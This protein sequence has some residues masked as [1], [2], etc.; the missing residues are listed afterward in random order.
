MNQTSPIERKTPRATTPRSRPKRAAPRSSARRSNS[1]AAGGDQPS[2]APCP[3]RARE[4]R[5]SR[6]RFSQ[7]AAFE[8]PL[9]RGEERRGGRKLEDECRSQSWLGLDTDSAVPRMHELKTE[10]Q[11]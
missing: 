5:G 4:T 10:E 2:P 11:T 7:R 6:F 3:L 1:R 8:L 9:G